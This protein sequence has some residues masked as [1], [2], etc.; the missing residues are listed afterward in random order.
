MRETKAKQID[1][2][3]REIEYR[4]TYLLNGFVAYIAIEDLE[5]LRSLPDVKNIYEIEQSRFMLDNSID[6]TLGTQF[7]ISDRRLATYGA[8][9]ELVP[10]TSPGH[11]ETPRVTALDGYEGQNINLA[12]IDSG[13]DWRHPMFGGIGQQTPLPRVSG[14]QAST[15]DNRKVIYYYAMSSPGDP[16]DDFGHGTLVASTAAGFAVDGNTPA[17][18]GFG[19]GRDNTGV[20]PTISGSRYHGTAPQARIMG[21]KVCGPAPQCAGDSALS[22][23]DAA[24]PYT[25]VRSATTGPI[26]VPKPIADVI[27][28][29]LGD[30]AGSANAASSVAANNAALN[31]T[32]VVASAGNA[33]PGAGT[34]GAPSAAALAISVAASLDPG[35]VAGADVLTNSQIPTDPCSGAGTRP[36][37]CDTATAPTAPATATENGTASNA[38]TADTPIGLKIFPVAG[39]GQLLNGSQSAHYVYVDLRD[40]PAVVP[41]SVGNRV[42]LAE[43]S[44]T[45]A[46]AANVLASQ[47][48]PP[49]AII[50]ITATESATAAAVVKGIPTYTISV[51][52]GTFLKQQLLA[53]ARQ[54]KARYRSNRFGRRQT[55]RLTL[56]HRQRQ[57]FHRAVR[58]IIRTRISVKSNRT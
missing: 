26:P 32:I 35:S 49:T 45:F 47:P 48:T 8:N 25:F 54:S 4:F 41:T 21:Y 5:R 36:A 33:G 42:A 28:L 9:Q 2:S 22:M 16:T 44:G 18:P 24:S 52:N 11:A 46:S 3:T 51:A 13:V 34:I 15:S 6:Y 7:N 27:N 38:N 37:M 31:G 56:I 12:I 39:G 40:N 43:F 50:L 23:E 19:L 20:G 29:S 58:T 1:G 14:N 30:T 57:V 17:I 53:S 10:L 55:S